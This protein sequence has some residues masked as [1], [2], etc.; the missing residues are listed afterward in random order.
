MTKSNAGRSTTG[1]PK[2]PYYRQTD[3][4]EAAKYLALVA[5]RFV[6]DR[7]NANEVNEAIKMWQGVE[8]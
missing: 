2:T 3:A 8:A 4:K 1:R 6:Q 7:A 5:R